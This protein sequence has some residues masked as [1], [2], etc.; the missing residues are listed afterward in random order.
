MTRQKGPL[1][2][3]S[4]WQGKTARSLPEVKENNTVLNDFSETHWQ[5]PAALLRFVEFLD[6]KMNSTTRPPK[7]WCLLMDVATVHTDTSVRQCIH[8]K[9]PHVS[10]VYIPGTTSFNQ[11]LDRAAKSALK[12]KVSLHYADLLVRETNLEENKVD[13][14]EK[15]L[16]EWQTLVH[17]LVRGTTSLPQ[18]GNASLLTCW[19]QVPCKA[20]HLPLGIFRRLC[21]LLH[22]F[23][24]SCR[25]VCFDSFG[26]YEK[27]LC[28]SGSKQVHEK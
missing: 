11:P 21:V 10:L 12:K 24:L 16:S 8:E 20:C 27:G 15:T 19:V 22:S 25:L 1:F 14:S 7:A 3:Q 9:F 28:W 13:I 23:A 18:L 6:R 26:L 4:I 2:A 5:T 17:A